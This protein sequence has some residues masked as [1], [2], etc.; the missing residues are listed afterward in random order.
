MCPWP[1]LRQGLGRAQL[2]APM[3]PLRAQEAENDENACRHHT[4][5]PVFHDTRERASPP[6]GLAPPGPGVHAS[7]VR[8]RQVVVVLRGQEGVL[9]RGAARP[10]WVCRRCGCCA[11]RSG[12]SRPPPCARPRMRSSDWPR[13]PASV[14]RV[15]VAGSHSLVPPADEVERHANLSEATEKA[16][17]AEPVTRPALGLPHVPPPT[18]R[19]RRCSST[20]RRPSPQRMGA[21]RRPRITARRAPHL[22]DARCAARKGGRRGWAG[23][24]GGDPPASLLPSHSPASVTAA[25]HAGARL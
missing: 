2:T 23:V 16:S 7:V 9:V 22:S 17:G 20:W 13:V 1:A 5:A 14:F 21:H 19:C 8:I 11:R 3:L 10:S 18:G 25:C 6:C 4:G 12:P 15:S 24:R